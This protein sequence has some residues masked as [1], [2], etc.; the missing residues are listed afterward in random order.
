MK[1]NFIKSKIPLVKNEAPN[2]L[3]RRRYLKPVVP[4]PEPLPSAL[5]SKIATVLRKF[6]EQIS[7]GTRP[8]KGDTTLGFIC[9]AFE[10]MC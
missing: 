4:Q 5:M 2:S 7:P 3:K 9:N 10:W 8:S 1:V 6:A